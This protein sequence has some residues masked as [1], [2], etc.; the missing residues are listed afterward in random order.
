MVG[1]SAGPPGLTSRVPIYS[2]ALPS[3][4]CLV[5]QPFDDGQEKGYTFTAT[6]TYRRLGV[7]IVEPVNVGGGPKDRR[8]VVH[9][10]DPPAAR[11]PPR[12]RRRG[13]GRRPDPAGRIRP[14]RGPAARV[15]RPWDYTLT[16]LQSGVRS[17][18]FGS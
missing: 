17:E 10:A 1:S 18:R 8:P 3:A 13:L 11:W 14:V 12:P 2:R 7:P 6:G 16:T 15:G 5:C 9:T 4:G